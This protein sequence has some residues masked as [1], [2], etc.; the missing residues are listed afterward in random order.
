[1]CDWNMSL[2]VDSHGYLSLIGFVYSAVIVNVSTSWSPLY[3]VCFAFPSIPEDHYLKK[4]ECTT[5]Y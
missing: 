5:D 1:M 3:F 4:K 2:F